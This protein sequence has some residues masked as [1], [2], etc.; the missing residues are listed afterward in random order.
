VEISELALWISEESFPGRENGLQYS[1]K[2][3]GFLLFWNSKINVTGAKRESRGIR[4]KDEQR[5]G[6]YGRTI[7]ACY[8]FYLL[9]GVLGIKLRVVSMLGKC[10]TTELH[11]QSVIFWERLSLYSSRPSWTWTHDLPSMSPECGD[12]SCVPS[13]LPEDL[14]LFWVKWWA[15]SEEGY[16][17][18]WFERI[19][20]AAVLR[21]A[22]YE[23]RTEGET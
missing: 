20:E 1:P 9:F 6:E 2:T 17:T 23:G 4:A 3:K 15:T 8:G 14:T 21:T 13:H 12:Y 19:I 22:L 11:H 18:G 10:P 7:W 16:N 5:M